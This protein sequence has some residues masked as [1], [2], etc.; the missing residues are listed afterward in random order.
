M[1]YLG[2]GQSHKW[3]E[4]K[5]FIVWKRTSKLTVKY[6]GKNRNAKPVVW[7]DFW[8][9]N[10]PQIQGINYILLCG[11]Y[12]DDILNSLLVNKFHIRRSD[13]EI[14]IDI[15]DGGLGEVISTI[16]YTC[17]NSQPNRNILHEL[18]GNS[19]GNEMK[20]DFVHFFYP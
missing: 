15:Y 7:P 20:A 12:D 10:P 9:W 3:I 17:M 6:L 1:K 4:K 16:L 13:E 18:K 2:H 5:V 8:A 14:L 11:L 19:L